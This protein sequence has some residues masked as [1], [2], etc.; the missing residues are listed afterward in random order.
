M[1][2]GLL[3]PLIFGVFCSVFGAAAIRWPEVIRNVSDRLAGP[4]RIPPFFSP[5]QVIWSI[6]FGGVV[7]SLMGYFLLWM[8]WRNR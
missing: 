7:S 3:G 1:R 8:V 6:R 4:R 2:E 5:S